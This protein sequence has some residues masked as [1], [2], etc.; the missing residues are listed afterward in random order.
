MANWLDDLDVAISENFL[1]DT[2]AALPT[3]GEINRRY[4]IGVENAIFR[5][6]SE[7]YRAMA[8]NPNGME[9]NQLILEGVNRSNGN[10]P[11]E[12]PMQ[13]TCGTGFNLVDADGEKADGNT[14]H[15]VKADPSLGYE[16]YS[17]R[18]GIGGLIKGLM[19]KWG[20]TPENEEM[21]MQLDQATNTT[22]VLGPEAQ[23]FMRW[24]LRRTG[25]KGIDGKGMNW[26]DSRIWNGVSLQTDEHVETDEKGKEKKSTVIIGLAGLEGETEKDWN[27]YLERL[28]EI[29]SDRPWYALAPGEDPDPKAGPDKPAT[30]GPTASNSAASTTKSAG[31]ANG[32]ASGA[33]KAESKPAPKKEEPKKDEAAAGGSDDDSMLAKLAQIAKDAE[34]FDGFKKTVQPTVKPFPRW[35]SWAMKEPNYIALLTGEDLTPPKK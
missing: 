33:A 23:R 12:Y 6:A 32:A 27:W 3:S 7:K 28:A 5:Q 21:C 1:S 11:E 15:H 16:K 30:G 25:G 31:T 24:H 35:I 26:N 10:K 29:G 14:S 13:L 20:V 4:V 17:G 9:I 34:D 2:A 19:E 18:S 22:F 8:K